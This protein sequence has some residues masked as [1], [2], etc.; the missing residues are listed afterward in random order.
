[1]LAALGV[2]FPI[3]VLVGIPLYFQWVM[4]FQ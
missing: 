3:N 1:M 2:T 4:L